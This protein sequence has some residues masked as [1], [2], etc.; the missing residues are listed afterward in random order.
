[1]SAGGNLLQGARGVLVKTLGHAGQSRGLGVFRAGRGFVDG[2]V[3][4]KG[5]TAGVL[6]RV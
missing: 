2:E 5:G 3:T 6:E 1:M 4:G